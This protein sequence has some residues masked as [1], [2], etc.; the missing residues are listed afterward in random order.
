MGTLALS[1]LTFRRLTASRRRMPE[2]IRHNST[3]KSAFSG[4]VRVE[5]TVG[6]VRSAA[7]RACLH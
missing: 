5:L 6:L 1:L 4:G 3:I 2:K 7:S